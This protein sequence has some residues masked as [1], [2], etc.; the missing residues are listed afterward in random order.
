MGSAK[1][2][3]LG[4]ERS[5]GIRFDYEWPRAL[6]HFKKSPLLGTGFSSLGLATDNDYLRALGET[7]LLGLL[8]FLL[9][10]L[11]GLKL[12]LEKG[13]K[14]W[15]AQAASASALAMLANACFID[16]LKPQRWLIFLVIIRPNRWLS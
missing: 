5:G 2:V 7:G 4:V 15:Q 10:F 3:E 16:V 14:S 8:S 13:R 1:S 9:I 6:N 12:I 11:E